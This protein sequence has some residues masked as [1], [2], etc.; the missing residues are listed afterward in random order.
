MKATVRLRI[1]GHL[2]RAAIVSVLPSTPRTMMMMVAAPAK[3]RNPLE[4]L[5][6]NNN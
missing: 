6:I 1:F 4:E 3:Y 2:M 5:H